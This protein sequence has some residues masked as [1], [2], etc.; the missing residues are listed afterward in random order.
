MTYYYK[1]LIPWTNDDYINFKKE[2]NA[3]GVKITPIKKSDPIYNKK[4]AKERVHVKYTR[5]DAMYEKRLKNVLL[6]FCK[7][8]CEYSMAL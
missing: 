2:L 8:L 7:Y 4:W 3:A 6:I 1:R 5:D